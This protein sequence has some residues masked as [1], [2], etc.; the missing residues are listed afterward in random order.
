MTEQNNKYDIIFGWLIFFLPFIFLFFIT[1]N[2]WG[3]IM[4]IVFLIGFMYWPVLI[5]LGIIIIL[6]IITKLK[7]INFP[8]KRVYLS[9]IF[10]I[11]SS[12]MLPSLQ[13]SH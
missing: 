5:G 1:E 2:E 12:A 8:I 3:P 4:S 11:L 9:I 10:C 13:T 7:V 6:K